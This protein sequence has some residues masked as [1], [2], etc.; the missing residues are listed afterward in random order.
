MTLEQI[1]ERQIMAM[2][3]QVPFITRL[4]STPELIT[5]TMAIFEQVYD[6]EERE[7]L[8]ALYS[9]PVGERM[10]S[11]SAAASQMGAQA[12]RK[13]VLERMEGMTD[14]EKEDIF[15]EIAAHGME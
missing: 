1:A 3:E 11:K 8:V 12:A 9:S 5:L 4:I 13:L 7:L 14:E 2:T 10:L 15:E 6:Q